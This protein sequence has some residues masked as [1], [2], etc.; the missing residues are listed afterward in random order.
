MI[1]DPTAISIS[2]QLAT[3]KQQLKVLELEE[4]LLELRLKYLIGINLGIDGAAIW[5]HHER[6]FLNQQRLKQEDE[7][8][9]RRFVDI[10]I[11]RTLTLL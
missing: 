1:V 2:T 4:E 11:Q 9:Y 5:S 10:R 6:S 8:T 3:V 7:K